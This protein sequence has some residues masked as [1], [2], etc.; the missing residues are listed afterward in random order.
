MATA[1]KNIWKIYERCRKLHKPTGK[2]LTSAKVT[3]E[4][5]K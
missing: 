1:V 3:S 4:T 5:T 2:K